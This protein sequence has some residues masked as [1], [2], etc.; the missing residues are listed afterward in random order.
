MYPI[1]IESGTHMY[2]LGETESL[3]TEC[4]IS[5]LPDIIH[6]CVSMSLMDVIYDNAW[7]I[8]LKKGQTIR[9]KDQDVYY[10]MPYHEAFTRYEYILYWFLLYVCEKASRVYDTPDTLFVPWIYDMFDTIVDQVELNIDETHFY[11]GALWV[12][13]DSDYIFRENYTFNVIEAIG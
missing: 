6:K 11:S 13:A 12:L 3:D 7:R 2:I 4:V 9:V 10:T 8:T 5:G 1:Y